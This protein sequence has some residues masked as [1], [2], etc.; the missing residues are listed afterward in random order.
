MSKSPAKS[1]ELSERQQAFV[2]NLVA[3]GNA[4]RAAREAGYSEAADRQTGYNLLLK[5]HI[6]EEVRRHTAAMIET[7]L[8][9][10]VETLAGLMTD[11]L[12][13]PRDRILA[14]STLLKLGKP[15]QTAAASVAMQVNIALGTPQDAIREV[16][17]SS[18][19]RKRA[20]MPPPIEVEVERG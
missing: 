5:P 6:A 4:A 12:I 3:H 11:P 17:E 20:L 13:E 8:P 15:S 9:S 19:A 7:A 2:H 16:W 14:A 18:E 10:A 1:R